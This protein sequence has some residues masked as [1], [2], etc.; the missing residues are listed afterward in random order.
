MPPRKIKREVLNETIETQPAKKSKV[1]VSHPSHCTTPGVVLTL[2]GGDVG[3]LGLGDNVMER[4]KPALVDIPEKTVQIIAGGM[5][6]V[7]LTEKGKI[8]TFGCN[9]EGALGRDTSEE[10][11]EYVPGVVDFH[12]RVVQISAG[13]S[14]TAALTD[15]GKVFAWGTFRVSLFI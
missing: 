5:H 13:D 14:H 3:Q 1:T 11:S 12:F 8:Y 2:G 9:D 6:T 7:C 4:K 10:G 15:D